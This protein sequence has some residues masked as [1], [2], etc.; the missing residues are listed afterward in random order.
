MTF[1][2]YLK[3]QLG[4]NDPIGDLAEDVQRDAQFPPV[5][6]LRELVGY[7]ES[8]GA[9]GDAVDAARDAWREYKKLT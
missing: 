8:H 6:S 9:C 3:S 1:N 4:R 5:K 2:K 7:L